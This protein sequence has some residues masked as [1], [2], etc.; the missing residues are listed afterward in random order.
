MQSKTESRHRTL[1]SSLTVLGRQQLGLAKAASSGRSSSTVC[2]GHEHVLRQTKIA[3]RS[4]EKLSEHENPG[5]AT[6]HVCP[7]GFDPT[8][9]TTPRRAHPG[10]RLTVPDCRHDLETLSDTVVLLTVAKRP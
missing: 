9:A 6:V 10:D 2:G 4:G 1:S 7:A 3:F 5:E 8:L